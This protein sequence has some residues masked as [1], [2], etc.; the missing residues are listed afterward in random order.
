MIHEHGL[1]DEIKS[2][3]D[4]DRSAGELRLPDGTWLVSPA[5]EIAPKA[6]H[7]VMF[8]PPLS[9]SEINEIEVALNSRLPSAMRELL[10]LCNGMSL[11]GR[12]ISIWGKRRTWE[13]TVDK[14]WQPFDIV[15]HNIES[16]RPA[17]SPA[18]V[19]FIG[20]ID[21]GEKW[22]FY[23]NSPETYGRIA[24]TERMLFSPSRYW[25]DFDTWILDKLE[26]TGSL[27]TE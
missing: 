9:L 8:A 6:W 25:P 15:H 21:Q 10:L 23:D 27:L 5:P 22:V 11:A 24:E 26:M 16:E 12:K 1:F 19:I 4:A 13:R 14:A 20:S 18:E 2:I 7:H 17:N 3:F